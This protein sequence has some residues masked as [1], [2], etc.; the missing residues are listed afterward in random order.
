[1]QGGVRMTLKSAQVLGEPQAGADLL[2][3]RRAGG[4]RG[5]ALGRDASAASET[6]TKLAQ[7]LSR[8][9]AFLAVF[10]HECMGQ[11][12]HFGPT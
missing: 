3:G 12:A 1:M 6:D 7:K 10:P 2:A 4:V 9:Q 11:L 5:A 8:I